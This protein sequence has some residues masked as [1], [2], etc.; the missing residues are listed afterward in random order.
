MAVHGAAASR[1]SPPMALS[2]FPA[3]SQARNRCA[4]NTQPSSAIEKGLTAQLINSVTPI[5]RQC[6]RTPASAV[7]STF[8]SIGTIM[9]QMSAATAKL[10][11]SA[12]K[13]AMA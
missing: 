13:A 8:I 5:P 3:G 6:A 9:S 4:R 12:W 2:I 11:S 10:T 1:I 7:K